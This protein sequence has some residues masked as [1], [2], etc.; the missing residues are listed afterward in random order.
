[1]S[2]QS[3]PDRTELHTAARTAGS[4]EVVREMLMNRADVNVTDK[5]RMVPLHLAALGGLAPTVAVLLKSK[6]NVHSSDMAG[7]TPLHL[8][9]RGEY[10]EVVRLLLDAKSDVDAQDKGGN[11]ALFWAPNEPKYSQLRSMLEV[12]ASASTLQATRYGEDTRKRPRAAGDGT[13]SNTVVDAGIDVANASGA[14]DGSRM[15][16]ITIR[17]RSSGSKRWKAIKR[18]FAKDRAGFCDYGCC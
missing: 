2:D 11:S 1:M 18:K 10:M 15:A 8:A 14:A 9:T 6:A 13:A 7:R 5:R 12:H 17:P 4:E 3:Q 16:L